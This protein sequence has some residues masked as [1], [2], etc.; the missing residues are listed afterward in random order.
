VDNLQIFWFCTSIK[1]NLIPA[2]QIAHTEVQTVT[3]I[4]AFVCLSISFNQFPKG[5]LILVGGG[6]LYLK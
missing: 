4:Q 6:M 1:N 2:I 3:R 5:L